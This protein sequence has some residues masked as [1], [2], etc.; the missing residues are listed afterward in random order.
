MLV[1][2]EKQ[3][4]TPAVVDRGDLAPY[5]CLAGERE[6]A[7]DAWT[8][9]VLLNSG[10]DRLAAACRPK[11]ERGLLYRTHPQRASL[12]GTALRVGP[13]G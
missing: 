6:R 5:S 13:D 1:P 7:I 12:I 3:V 11:G 9:S 2:S 4:S 10:T 8:R